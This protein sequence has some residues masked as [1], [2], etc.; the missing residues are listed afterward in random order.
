MTED[1]KKIKKY[2]NAVERKLKV[3]LKMKV[4]INAH[5]GTD[6]HARM[7]AGWSV[8]KILEDREARKR[9]RIGL[10]RSWERRET[11]AVSGIYF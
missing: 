11:P 9:W 3:P 2:V 8:D 5:L 4:R 1:Q 6:I 10:T 7:E